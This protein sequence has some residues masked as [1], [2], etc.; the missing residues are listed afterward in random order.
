[1]SANILGKKPE[2]TDFYPYLESDIEIEGRLNESE[3]IYRLIA[4]HASDMIVIVD[5]ENLSYTY[6]SPSVDK[7]LGYC[8]NSMLGHHCLELVHPD[9][10][11]DV[12]EFLLA[13][14][15]VGHGLAQYRA[16]K[17]DGTV[18]WL[19]S[20]GQFIYN[21]KGKYEI[22]IICRDITE[23]KLTEEALQRSEEKYRLIVDNAYDGISIISIDN[24]AGVYANPAILKSLGYS[25]EEFALRKEL[26]NVHPDDRDRILKALQ[27]GTV[28]KEGTAEL[29]FI[30]KDGT[31]LWG[32]VTGKL[33]P[34]KDEPSEI[35][36]FSRDI[37]ERKKFDEALIR[38]EL[39]LRQITDN[40]LDS[41]C[42]LNENGIFEY[43][44]P[45]Q[46]SILGFEVAEMTGQH[47]Q[48]LLH[49]D[50]YFRV[51]QS[52]QAIIDNESNGKLE[53][54]AQH[55]D[56]HY[57]WLES[58][59]RVFV[60]N[61][62]GV[63]QLVAGT[64]DISA[65]K[66]AEAELQ[67]RE[68]DLRDKVNYLN[69]LIDNMNELC[70]TIDR[71][72][73]LTFGNQKTLDV[74]GY[75]MEEGLGRSIFDFIP[76]I[77][78]ELVMKNFRRRIEKGETG[79]YEHHITC[80]DGRIILAK[81]K[82]SPIIEDGKINGIL[83]LAEDITQQRKLE[84]EMSRLGQLNTVGEMAASIGHEIRN[85]MTTV[86][87]FLQIMSQ[88][89]QL[90]EQ[91]PYFDL[92]L[93]ELSRANFII[94]EFLSFAKDR[95][96]NLQCHDLNRILNVL[97]PLL[98]A[99]ATKEDKYISF[100]FGKISELLLDEKEI[101]QLILNLVRNALEAMSAGGKVIIR[102]SQEDDG[103]LLSVQDEGEGIPPKIQEQL[104]TPFLTS[105][106]NGTGLGLAVCYSIVARHKANLSYDTGPKGSNFM[107]KFYNSGE[108]L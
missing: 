101:R 91:Q 55:K 60:D 33:L 66:Q 59:C 11:E 65:R 80:K 46:K 8:A 96:V 78:K 35:L 29:R 25:E 16:M 17:N 74:T 73:K 30:K 5:K 32:E 62:S 88:N 28:R 2:N 93:E 90:K 39:R 40:M 54:R 27:E 43:V 94:T 34:A 99:D 51:K 12:R 24:Y 64:R 18:V 95:L 14:L 22:L 13:G 37:G 56:G 48:Q 83:V 21:E 36:I 102:T 68:E 49:P 41:I 84:K 81:V 57:V 42:V 45:S 58:V 105:K 104:G 47:N 3:A 69:T 61:Y 19:E 10:K 92:M 20:V 71:N 72:S 1:M 31:Y 70:Y 38:S 7:I 85:P 67:Q 23:R 107:V 86:Q 6:V 77:D 4:E 97:A 44:S 89:E 106:E 53:Y 76:D 79:N 9:D 103:V 52:V 50:D 15:E 63:K 100:S 98:V 75:T 108:Q 82:S 87:G 26:V